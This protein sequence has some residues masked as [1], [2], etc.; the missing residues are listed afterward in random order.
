MLSSETRCG[1]PPLPLPIPSFVISI[2]DGLTSLE[3]AR[4]KK[5]DV[6]VEEESLDVKLQGKPRLPPLYIHRM[7]WSQEPTY[8]DYCTVVHLLR[9]YYEE[10]A[11]PPSHDV[12]RITT[13]THAGNWQCTLKHLPF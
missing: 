12:S 9:K 13:D 11:T 2:K 10:P 1:F 5:D 4:A 8:Y 3:I 6:T 7:R